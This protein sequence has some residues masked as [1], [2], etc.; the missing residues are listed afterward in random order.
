VGLIN[1]QRGISLWELP[2]HVEDEREFLQRGNDDA[3]AA[4]ECFGQLCGVLVDL[5]NL[6]LLVFKL[7][8]RVL[9]L[10]IPPGLFGLP[11]PPLRPLLKGRKNV[12]FPASRVAMY[13][14]PGSTAKCTCRLMVKVFFL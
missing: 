13:T 7:V 3:T 2:D 5:L 14:S 8:N 10:P 11:Q 9:Q 6:R 1:D 4:S 12:L